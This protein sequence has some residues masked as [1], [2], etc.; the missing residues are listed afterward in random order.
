MYPI[1]ARPWPSAPQWFIL[2]TGNSGPSIIAHDCA[3]RLGLERGPETRVENTGAGAG[4]DLRISRARHPVTLGAVGETLSVPEPRV[5]TLTHVGKVEGRRV[6]GLLGADF[7]ARHVV[8]LDYAK[9]RITLRD[10]AKYEPPPGAIV[11]PLDVRT[12]WPIVD[13]TITPA[14]GKPIP[15]RLI[16]DTG[17]RFTIALHRPFSTRHGL[18]EGSGRLRDVVIGS[19]AGGVSRGDVGR[20]DAL[21]LG[22]LTVERPTAIFSRDTVGAFASDEPEGIVGGELL[23]RHRVTFDYPHQR[24]IL[25]PYPRQGAH[26]YDMSGLFLFVDAP[27]YQRIRILSVAPH[28]PASE[29]GLRLDDEIVAI[30][31]RSTPALTLDAARQMLRTPGTKR[32]RVRRDGQVLEMRLEARRLI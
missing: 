25:E 20:L 15:C 21:T 12:G 28:T 19:G 10:P 13:G 32:I 11:V 7:M 17:V 22:P 4:A 24:M 3:E 23:V 1:R 18:L 29:A 5:L 26:E 27:D 9:R 14:G 6:D 30:G 31:N 8:E 16:I 2:D